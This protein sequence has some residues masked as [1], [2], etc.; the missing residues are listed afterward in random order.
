MMKKIAMILLV[1]Y[2]I[3]G[4][5]KLPIGID[6]PLNVFFTLILLAYTL[7]AKKKISFDFPRGFI[8]YWFYISIVYILFSGDFRITT[9]IPGGLS[10]C[11]WVIAFIVLASFF[12]YKLF[13]K[14]YRVV[15]SICAVVFIIQEISYYTL[16]T[17]PIF[18]FPMP[19]TGSA[20]YSVILANQINLDRSSCFFREPSHFAQFAL[21]LL[22][23]E[24]YESSNKGRFISRYAFF[25]VLILFLMRSGNGFLGMIIIMLVQVWDYLKYAKLKYKYLTLIVIIPLAVLAVSLY[26]RTEQGSEIAL[27]A[28]GISTEEGSSSFVRTFRGFYLYEELPV[29]NKIFGTSIEGVPDA[30][31]RSK[32]NYLFIDP[33]TGDDDYYLNGIQTIL[34]SNGII[35]LL[36]FFFIYIKLYSRYD[37]L[38]KPLILLFISLLFIGNLYLSQMMLI[39][40]I[41][42]MLN[43]QRFN[44]NACSYQ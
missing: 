44:K 4:I 2:P 34:I 40:T 16:G 20:D 19:L 24:L 30:I 5:Y 13:R 35:G 12:D 21:P 39:S 25:I 31:S 43:K 38:S 18:L 7:L 15:F 33:I 37:L 9:L 1:L 6:I 41:I 8:T 36:L 3:L 22:A 27:R 32:V 29:I 26:S 17:R 14:Y 11:F 28:S 23:I 42:P 10:F